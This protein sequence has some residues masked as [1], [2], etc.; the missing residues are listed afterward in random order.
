MKIVKFIIFWLCLVSI[1]YAQ[2]LNVVVQVNASQVQGSD[3][4]IFETLQ[5]SMFEFMNGRRWTDLNFSPNERIECSFTLVIQ[6]YDLQSNEISGSLSVQVRRPI[7]NSTYNSVLLNFVDRDISFRY[8]EYDPLQYADGMIHN[9][10]T[11][12]LAYYANVALGLTFSSFGRDAGIPFFDRAMD[13]VM[14][15]Q[16]L[17][18]AENVGWRSSSR[19]SANRYWLVE[20]FTNGNLRE[21]HDVYF[22]YYRRGM[23]IIYDN[24]TGARQ[25]ILQSLEKLQNVNRVRPGLLFRQIFFDATSEEIINVFRMGTIDEKNKLI[26]LARVLDPANLNK[27]QAILN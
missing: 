17:L 19:N 20:N 18:G 8:A 21:I 27:Y 6:S 25:A 2:E 1:G 11:A 7:F 13:I 16:D 26:T 9:N 12:I 10:L 14:R 4:R 3:R 24:P 22:T 5:S 15:C 23:D